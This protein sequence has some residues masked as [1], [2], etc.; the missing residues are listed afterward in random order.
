MLVLRLQRFPRSPWAN[1]IGSISVSGAEHQSC[2]SHL[3][4]GTGFLFCLL[5]FNLGRRQHLLTK[6]EEGKCDHLL[7]AVTWESRG[8]RCVSRTH[9]P[10][11][12]KEEHIG[13]EIMKIHSYKCCAMLWRLIINRFDSHYVTEVRS[14]VRMT[15]RGCLVT[16]PF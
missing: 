12:L 10:H 5:A 14:Q 16:S 6:Q 11:R 3:A 13:K 9:V 1:A 15:G 8:E 7:A 2:G 4:L